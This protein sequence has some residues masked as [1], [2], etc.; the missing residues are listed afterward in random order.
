MLSKTMILKN[1]ILR[2]LIKLIRKENSLELKLCS[3][4]MSI[5][6]DKAPLMD[7]YGNLVVL[8]TWV[9]KIIQDHLPNKTF[10]K[11]TYKLM[12]DNHPF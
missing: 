3:K 6:K 7:N 8:D 1:K 10:N 4:T 9:R 11:S 5:S 12:I 2:N